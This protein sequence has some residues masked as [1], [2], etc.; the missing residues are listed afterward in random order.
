[1]FVGGGVVC[2]VCGGDGFHKIESI[3][4]FGFEDIFCCYLLEFYNLFLTFVV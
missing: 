3:F 2:V 4:G 1:M